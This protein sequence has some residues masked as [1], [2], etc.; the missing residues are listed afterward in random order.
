MHASCDDAC[1]AQDG[2]VRRFA[3]KDDV[4]DERRLITRSIS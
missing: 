3:G 2:Q 4:E 1:A